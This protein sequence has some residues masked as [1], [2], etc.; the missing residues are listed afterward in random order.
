MWHIALCS[1]R[2]MC[3]YVLECIANCLQTVATKQQPHHTDLEVCIRQCSHR[4]ASVNFFG[5]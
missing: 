2:V 3:N 4:L 1:T 5:Q